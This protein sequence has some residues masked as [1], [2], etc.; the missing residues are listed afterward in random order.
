MKTKNI[1][2]DQ[3][4]N[5]S[6]FS[7]E[8][9]LYVLKSIRTIEPDF[10]LNIWEPKISYSNNLLQNLTNHNNATVSPA[11]DLLTNEEMHKRI[12]QQLVYEFDGLLTVKSVE[13][14]TSNKRMKFAV[15]FPHISF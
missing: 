4:I 13:N 9:L 10:N 3:V 11:A 5:E 1:T 8:D 12:N 2:L 6:Y 14:M 7:G 15:N